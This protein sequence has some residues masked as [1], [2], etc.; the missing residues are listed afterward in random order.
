MKKKI[1]PRAESRAL[2]SR[3]MRAVKSR[4]TTPER[5]VRTLVSRLGYRFRLIRADLPGKP[6]L[7]FPKFRSVVFVHGCF[8]HGH[9]C[10]RGARVPR[11]NVEYWVRKI[12]GNRTRDAKVRAELQKTGWRVLTIWECQLKREAALERRIASFLKQGTLRTSRQCPVRASR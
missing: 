2:R 7:T 5:I 8:W 9:S 11:T 10:G 6:D 1:E 3:V 12:S 4:D